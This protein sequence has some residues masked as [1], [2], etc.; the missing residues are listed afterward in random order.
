MV[1]NFK[2]IAVALLFGAS[3]SPA[4][5]DSFYGALDIGQSTVKDN[6]TN[7][8]PGFSG[9][10]DSGSLFRVAGGYQFVPMWGAE[11][12]Y[13]A[14]GKA[15]AGT[16][17]PVSVND[18]QIS[19]LQ[20]SGIGTLPVAD[21]FS[22]LVKLGIASTNAKVSHTVSGSEGSHSVTST[23]L[24]YGIGAQYDFTKSTSARAQ[25]EDLG[26]VGD[27]NIGTNKVTLLSV[28]VVYKF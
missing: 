17:G 20:L 18:W 21:G 7:P 28:G 13:G 6:C 26:T 16:G 14:Y 10:K 4:M 3:S 24:A 8:P 27:S 5:A 25:Y 22:V 15:S 9:C 23:K 11:V 12:S 19:G 1:N 2:V